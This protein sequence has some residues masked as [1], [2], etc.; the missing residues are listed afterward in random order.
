[1]EQAA[2]QGPAYG[3]ELARLREKADKASRILKLLANKNR[4]LILCELAHAGEKT[5]SPLAAAVGLSQSALSQHLSRLRGEGL[6]TQRRES[7]MVYYRIADP[8][9]ERILELLIDLYC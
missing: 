3:Q 2:A 4:L 5:V 6:V 9:I 1:M 8:K 7:Q